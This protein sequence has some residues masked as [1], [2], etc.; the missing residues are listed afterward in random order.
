M[1]M[2]Q[3]KVLWHNFPIPSWKG[4]H[5]IQ[6]KRT[7]EIRLLNAPLIDDKDRDKR[8]IYLRSGMKCSKG[9]SQ[10]K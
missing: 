9:P 2:K 1:Y 4:L 5:H 7:S 6:D 3:C 8:D 10:V